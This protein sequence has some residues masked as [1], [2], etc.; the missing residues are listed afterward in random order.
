MNQ[1]VT[2]YIRGGVAVV[3]IDNPPVN[4]LS[5]AVRLGL[6]E[7]V[8]A[9]IAEPAAAIVLICCAG[10][11]FVAG[12]D[13]TE[14]AAF[15][16]SGQP[17]RHPWL[18][19]VLDAIEAS[20]KPVVT[21]VHGTA[22]GGGFEL[23]LA[24]HYRCAL[25]AAKL[26]LPEVNLGLIPGAGGTQRAPRLAGVEAALELMTGGRPI[27]ARQA[28]SLGLVDEV[29]DADLKTAALAWCER[30]VAAGSG[31][32]Q[33]SARAVPAVAGEVFTAARA[34]LARRARNQ[35]APQKVV[36][37]VEAATR[38][39]FAE[40][41][42]YE[43]ARFAEC[44]ASPQSAAMRHLFFAERQAARIRGLP[45]E[46]VPRQVRAV[47]IVGAGTMGGGI[48]MSVADA[49]LPVLLLDADD[50]G[51]ERGLDV[52]R[53]RYRKSVSKGRLS[54]QDAAR[55]LGLIES[56]TDYGAL[57]DVDLVIEAVFEDPALKQR[58][59]K[60]L[61][62][63]AKPGAIL[64]TNTSYQ[65]VD[66]IAAATSR[67]ADCLGLHFFSPANVMK[68]LEVVR[69]AKTADPVLSTAMH[70]AKTLRKVPVMA[71]VC[72]GFIGNRMFNPYLRE[73]Q[74]LL[75]EGASPEAVDHALYEFGM[76]M[77][78]IAVADLAGLDIGYKARQALPADRR[79]GDASFAVA[80]ALV[81]QGRLGQ[82]T[83]AG[84][85]TYDPDTRKATLEPEVT[86]LIA[87]KRRELGIKARPV[88][89]DEIVARCVLALVNEGLAL[90]EEGIAQRPGDIDVVY[91]YGYGFP[92]Y[93]GGPMHYAD[94][95]G[96]DR[97]LERVREFQRRFGSR[98]PSPL[99]E[100]LVAEGR[101]IADWAAD[102]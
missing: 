45:Q 35:L 86:E 28:Q 17:P 31:V 16:A 54:E 63:V 52:I 8:A 95:I 91:L 79:G 58:V 41:A 53:G 72:Y 20:A 80:D 102:G 76:A 51:L 99:L 78:P 29:F 39:P 22:L 37:C 97:V 27:G 18:P 4:A 42:E 77:G 57:G 12:A 24:S 89:A 34:G 38:L 85:Y 56:T 71:G 23:V 70:F 94:A 49:G 101:R 55:R 33:V 64:A 21:A 98:P 19:E 48:A 15:A 75:L 7:T 93:R 69:G 87:A 9:A 83:G 47:G 96:L 65:D 74:R 26:G 32:R 61:D 40:G 11:T 3:T 81:A 5:H 92:A 66:A 88:T 68:L 25:A 1:P 13:I 82:K 14:F 30:L 50:A 90:L 43:R 10:R 44:L 6:H 67:P 59:F 46:T 60:T 62:E 73:A 36:D 84:F 2:L 100:R